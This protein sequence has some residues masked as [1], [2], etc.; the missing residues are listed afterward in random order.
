MDPFTVV[1][2]SPTTSPPSQYTEARMAVPGTLKGFEQTLAVQHTVLIAHETGINILQSQQATAYEHQVAMYNKQELM[3]EQLHRQ[4]ET[5]CDLA[6]SFH[7]ISSF[8]S[9]Y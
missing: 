3:H 7:R 5:L 6:E 9:P 2:G 1:S 4:D 8:L